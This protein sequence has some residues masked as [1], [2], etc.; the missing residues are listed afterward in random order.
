MFFLQ[1]GAVGGDKG[2]ATGGVVLPGQVHFTQPQRHQP[3]AALPA[4]QPPPPPH[5]H[6]P[7]PPPAMDEAME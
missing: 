2:G 4:A 6:P 5:H 1:H 7:P 3:A